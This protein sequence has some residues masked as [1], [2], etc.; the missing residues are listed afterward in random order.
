MLVLHSLLLHLNCSIRVT[1]RA[2]S[3]FYPPQAVWETA[4]SELVAPLFVTLKN[5]TF[6]FCKSLLRA[7]RYTQGC[8][9]VLC[10]PWSR[11]SKSPGS[12]THSTTVNRPTCDCRVCNLFDSAGWLHS[13][14]RRNIML[15]LS[16][17][18]CLIGLSSSA[19]RRF[20]QFEFSP[21]ASFLCFFRAGSVGF[22]TRYCQ[23]RQYALFFWVR[24]R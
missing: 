20:S 19:K 21:L 5:L 22:A 18:T 4:L 16:L 6:V 13:R 1:H 3:W 12:S 10:P 14:G 9:W 24:T 23:S 15:Q 8:V 11:L 7:L 17:K 2:S